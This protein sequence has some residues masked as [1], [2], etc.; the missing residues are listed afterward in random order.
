MLECRVEKEEKMMRTSFYIAK[1]AKG[2]INIF[3]IFAK[4]QITQEGNIIRL[5][6]VILNELKFYNERF[7]FETF[8]NSVQFYVI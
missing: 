3:M 8:L 4:L 1:F 2:A 6:N 5:K 7:L